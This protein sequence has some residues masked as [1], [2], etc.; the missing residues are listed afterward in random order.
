MISVSLSGGH[1][2]PLGLDSWPVCFLHCFM[3]GCRI[4]AKMII[5]IIF[6][7][8]YSFS[9]SLLI[10]SFLCIFSVIPHHRGNL[11]AIGWWCATSGTM[12]QCKDFYFNWVL[13]DVLNWLFIH[14]SDSVACTLRSITNLLLIPALPPLLVVS[15]SKDLCP[16]VCCQSTEWR[17]TDGILETSCC[18][19]CSTF[20]E[21]DLSGKGRGTSIQHDSLNDLLFVLE[22]LK[23]P[24]YEPVQHPKLKWG[25]LK[26][27]FVLAIS[28]TKKK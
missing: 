9:F 11:S 27:A 19:H 4:M 1:S 16:D 5:E 22:T 6:P 14:V 28:S 15:P 8:K 10:S 13:K 25:S 7:H 18:S 21:L 24:P 17:Y 12:L 20:G 26:M 23:T 3:Q 2:W